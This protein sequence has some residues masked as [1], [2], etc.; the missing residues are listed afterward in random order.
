MKLREIKDRV[1]KMREATVEEL[2]RRES[3]TAEEMFHLRF[4]WAMGQTETLRKL[5]DLQKERARVL[6]VLREKRAQG[7][8][9]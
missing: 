9:S 7:G 8:D 2:H 6:T 5:R 4:R 3:E 1:G